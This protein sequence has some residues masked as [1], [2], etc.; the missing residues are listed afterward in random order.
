[1]MTLDERARSAAEGLQATV[2][3]AIPV[4]PPYP[5]PTAMPQWLRPVLTFALSA[6]IVTAGAFLISRPEP[7]VTDLP[8]P[9]TPV[10]IDPTVP[11]STTST[12]ESTPTSAR[13]TEDTT[14]TSEADAGVA[15]AP[16]EEA[17]V[18][19]PMIQI[20]EPADGARFTDSRLT[21]KGTTEPG[22]VVTFGPFEADV[23]SAGNWSIVLIL[24]EGGNRTTAVATDAA[25]NT[26][27]A[28]VLVYLDPPVTTTV[29]KD[30]PPP[31]EPPKEEPPASEP[32]HAEQLYGTCAEDP[33]YD[34]FMGTGTP[35]HTVKVT[36]EYG[37][38]VTTI[39]ETGSFEIQ[40]FFE[41]APVDEPFAVTVKDKETG[42]SFVFEFVHTG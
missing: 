11:E 36:S 6:V 31:E 15:P 40:V 9:T 33:P 30:E 42:E 16:V 34:V 37:S 12:I 21:F 20:L 3:R 4:A 29:P 32:F 22:A 28:S 17:D 14:V 8:D 25:G 38:G 23:D 1:M 2:T 13:A 5:P 26:S 41:T 35:G 24:S 27:E 7:R 19:P 39:D 10:V 18:T